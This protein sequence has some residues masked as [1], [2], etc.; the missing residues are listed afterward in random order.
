MC[1]VLATEWSKWSVERYE[2]QF[3]IIVANQKIA[4]DCGK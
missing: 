1:K 4:L 2:C 3:N